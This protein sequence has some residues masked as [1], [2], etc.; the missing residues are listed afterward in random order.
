LYCEVERGMGSEEERVLENQ[1]ELQLHEQRDSLTAID[2]AL[3]L[4]PTNSELLEVSSISIL[5]LNL[6]LLGFRLVYFMFEYVSDTRT[7]CQC[8]TRIQCNLT[9]V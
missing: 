8:R 5:N 2:H 7:T 9:R 1:L 4:D 3:L 6:H